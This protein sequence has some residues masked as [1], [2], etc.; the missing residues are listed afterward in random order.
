MIWEGNFFHKFN[1]YITML[2][3]ELIL[4]II[5]NIVSG[6]NKLNWKEMIFI[7]SRMSLQF[8]LC[9]EEYLQRSLGQY[10]KKKELKLFAISSLSIMSP[11]IKKILWEIF[12]VTLIE[13][14]VCGGSCLFYIGY[15]FVKLWFIVILAVSIFLWQIQLKFLRFFSSGSYIGESE[16]VKLRRLY[17]LPLNCV[18]LWSANNCIFVIGICN[19]WIWLPFVSL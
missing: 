12:F 15:R 10:L 18:P 19:T 16:F 14:F 9:V 1:W 7:L 6:S 3:F 13:H 11:L 17:I 2:C 5:P 8:C 4:M